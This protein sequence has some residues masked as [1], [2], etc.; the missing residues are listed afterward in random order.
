[1]APKE[2]ESSQSKSEFSVL[3]SV[4]K[5]TAK[6]KLSPGSI[7]KL[8]ALSEPSKGTVQDYDKA[9]QSAEQSVRKAMLS[10]E[11]LVK[12]AKAEEERKQAHE[13]R[14]KTLRSKKL[15]ALTDEIQKARADGVN[16]A[17]QDAA[18][19]GISEGEGSAQSDMSESEGQQSDA[20][21]AVVETWLPETVEC[22]EPVGFDE[23][24]AP[25]M[26]GLKPAFFKVS[27]ENLKLVGG[28]DIP[29]PFKPE[30]IDQ[31]VKHPCLA[32]TAK[33]GKPLANDFGGCS[34]IPSL[35][36]G[37]EQLNDLILIR[38]LISTFFCFCVY[39]FGSLC[40]V[41]IPELIWKSLLFNS[42]ADNGGG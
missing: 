11:K 22:L 15:A 31:L 5:T 19:E 21:E 42:E 36:Y 8:Q 9:L 29:D 4:T 24:V 26:I 30:E 28:V 35:L 12:E 1:M 3:N 39:L 18:G 34:F 37:A 6:E 41:S 7:N 20:S 23:D 13:E 27:T 25:E 14:L 16:S 32:K 38:N 40:G 17:E 33:L 10:L 2:I